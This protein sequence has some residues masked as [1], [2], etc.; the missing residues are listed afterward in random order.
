ME[1]VAG[2]A[3]CGSVENLPA[4][5]I[6]VFLGYAGHASNLKRTFFLD[7]LHHRRDSGVI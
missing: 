7:K 2:E 1:A 4:A 3:A 5:G 6:E